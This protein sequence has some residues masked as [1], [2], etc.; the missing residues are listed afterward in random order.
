MAD[1]NIDF[2]KFVKDPSATPDRVDPGNV[3]FSKF[4]RSAPPPPPPAPPGVME[5][6]GAAI[7]GAAV[8]AAGSLAGGGVGKSADESEIAYLAS[9]QEA[10]SPETSITKDPLSGALSVAPAKTDLLA[11][12][13]NAPL[14]EEA[15]GQIKASLAAMPREQRQAAVSRKRLPNWMRG[16][17]SEALRQIDAEDKGYDTSGAMSPQASVETR[18]KK[19]VADGMEGQSADSW[20]AQDA[21]MGGITRQLGTMKATNNL[22]TGEEEDAAMAEGRQ[23]SKDSVGIRGLYGAKQGLVQAGAGINAALLH[24]LGDTKGAKRFEKISAYREAAVNGANELDATRRLAEDLGVIAA[25][26]AAYFERMGVAGINSVGQMVPSILAGGLTALGAGNA[27]AGAKVAMTL[28]SSQVFGQE[29]ANPEAVQKLSPAERAGRAGIM[30]ALEYVGERYGMLPAAM[31][32]L[33]GKAAAVEMEELPK[34]AERA[35]VAMEKRGLL[36][37][38]MANVARVQAGEQIGEQITGSGQYLLDGTSMGL[39]KPISFMGFLENARDTAVQTVIATGVLQGAGA[40]GS[41]LM[42][43]GQ[44]LEPTQAEAPANFAQPPGVTPQMPG[45]PNVALSPAQ[46]AAPAAPATPAATPAAPFDAGS[47][48]GTPTDEAAHQAATSPTNDR[49]EPTDA[50]KDAGNYAKGHIKLGGLDISIENPQGSKRSGTDEDGKAWETEVQSHYGYIRRT[51]GADGDHVDAFIKPGTADNYD[52]PVFVVDQRNPKTGAFDEHKVMLGFASPQEAQDAYLA[53]YQPG[54]QGLGYL[55]GL[56]MPAFK[57][58][59][60]NGNHKT[61]FSAGFRGPDLAAPAAQPADSSPAGA[62]AAVGSSGPDGLRPA[63]AGGGIQTPAA[64]PVGS[65]GE[66]VAPGVPADQPPSALSD[67]PDFESTW[68]APVQNPDGKGS[69]FEGLEGEY[70]AN[71]I[72]GIHQE[73]G[74]SVQADAASARALIEG[75][76]SGVDPATGKQADPERLKAMRQELRDALDGID[77][78]LGDYAGEFGE[79]HKQAFQDKLLPDLG[80]MLAQAEEIEKPGVDTKA[81]SRPP[82][83]QSPIKKPPVGLDDQ[84][85]GVVDGSLGVETK[86][87]RGVVDAVF[88]KHGRSAF[89]NGGDLFYPG[90]IKGQTN[91]IALPPAALEYAA[92][93]RDG[94]PTKPPVSDKAKRAL[95]GIGKILKPAAEAPSVTSGVAVETAPAAGTPDHW[96]KSEFAPRI[97][98]ALNSL[99]DTGIAAAADLARVI[100]LGLD[101]EKKPIDETR[102]AFTEDL[103]KREMSRWHP[104][105]VPWEPITLEALRA[106]DGVIKALP[107]PIVQAAVT[108]LNELGPRLARHGFKSQDEVNGSH[109]VSANDIA[110]EMREVVG[111]LLGL[112]P[113]RYSEAI[114]R[115]NVNPKTIGRAEDFAS[116]VLNIDTRAHPGVDTTDII[117]SSGAKKRAQKKAKQVS[118]HPKKVWGSTPLAEISRQKGGLSPDLL[119]DLSFRKETGKV[120]KNG[121]IQTAWFNPP[122]YGMKGGLF[123]EGG[124]GDTNELAEWMEEEGYIPIGTMADDY[125]KGD[126]LARKLVTQAL[127]RDEPKTELEITN[128]ADDYA[129]REREAW[130]AL[131]DEEKAAAMAA[132]GFYP[133]LEPDAAEEVEAD[134]RE[135]MEDE[136]ISAADDSEVDSADWAGDGD[137]SWDNTERGLRNLG[138]TD[139]EIELERQAY[140]K[141]K[142]SSQ[143][144]AGPG[145]ADGASKAGA[146]PA[147]A[148]PAPRATSESADQEDLRV[149]ADEAI[150]GLYDGQAVSLA[151]ALGVDTS[152]LSPQDARTILLTKNPADVMRE[153]APVLESYSESDLRQKAERERAA[154]EAAQAEQR[155]LAAKE[156]ARKRALNK[157]EEDARAEQIRKERA[158]DAVDGFELGQE[159]P[160]A[161]VSRAE[162]VG[163]GDIFGVSQVAPNRDET[164][165]ALRKRLSV[166]KSLRDCLG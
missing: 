136:G 16:A 132:D 46:P 89:L 31:K 40:L 41:G 122:V 47:L 104:Q 81:D 17:M 67:T 32:G 145:V 123:R 134:R 56:D 42:R 57:E 59:V 162:A 106:K 55:T 97:N 152:T 94:K 92:E 129:K 13:G 77:S 44:R 2:S 79:K 18:S 113:A 117:G 138:F 137:I 159:P 105:A 3:D 153:I 35:V 86:T 93:K 125:Q 28:M 166:L 107:D 20:G 124:L 109:P 131:S 126:E 80:D 27:A 63:D 53:N 52:G 114:Q 130:D 84:V 15:F 62:P 148:A 151:S 90:S 23:L 11:S 119:H 141:E 76:G 96:S 133:D 144:G 82:E 22:L 161:A 78:T 43:R 29:F 21:Q 127:N 108:R 135:I 155:S 115:K 116:R 128:E 69:A 75:I 150:S 33:M 37:K 60:K 6:A 85:R 149:Q 110:R 58:W 121:K 49:P 74:F 30:A 5:R 143:E 157:A 54:W 4:I 73:V 71:A 118:T 139:E 112:A 7:K 38:P 95:E 163:Q 91:S 48:L 26:P 19:L 98:A 25:T 100:R 158:D 120:M 66:A 154:A 101:S 146:V 34:W 70:L 64:G 142:R 65:S 14:S 61:P 1:Q 160:S 111:A 72:T 9:D 45:V 36:S 24:A 8:S 103:V 99:E 68:P 156:G 12:R 102:A 83:D 140:E 10:N 164:L 87:W 50:Q 147:D 165:V 51:E 88:K 39:D